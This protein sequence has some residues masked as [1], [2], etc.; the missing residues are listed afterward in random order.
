MILK[1][2]VKQIVASHAKMSPEQQDF[3]K[4]LRADLSAFTLE[5]RRNNKGKQ[6]AVEALNDHDGGG[7]AFEAFLMFR[8][9]A[10]LERNGFLTQICNS[11]GE[12]WGSF[13]LR[14]APGHLRR[15]PSKA[16]T[17]EPGFIALVIDD[18]VFEMHNSVEWPDHL[19]G[20]ECHEFDVSIAP[21][22]ACSALVAWYQKK[23]NGPS[24]LLGIEAKFRGAAP[25]KDLAREMTGLAVRMRTPLVYLVSSKAAGASVVKQLEALS[26]VTA[27]GVRIIDA[28]AIDV[29][30]SMGTIDASK[31]AR[32]SDEVS[33]Q[34]KA[35]NSAEQI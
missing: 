13:I 26:H 30:M 23:E 12:A 18:K 4:A 6:V 14:G 7:K 10:N 11:M 17:V 16:G 15:T 24:P 22:A 21:S 19:A 27:L 3:L 28:G 34:I 29:R 9:K 8:L 5:V 33:R 25:Q 2:E 20:G 1:T 35:Q 32:I 31:L